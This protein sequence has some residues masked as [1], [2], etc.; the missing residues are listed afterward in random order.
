MVVKNRSRR[1]DWY[2]RNLYRFYFM[3]G[4][5]HVLISLLV[6][7]DHMGLMIL[8]YTT[9][10]EMTVL[11]FVYSL[12]YLSI[13]V[14]IFFSF[15]LKL[16]RYTRKNFWLVLPLGVWILQFLLLYLS[17]TSK[18]VGISAFLSFF[19]YGCVGF[20][21]GVK[22]INQIRKHENLELNRD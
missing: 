7:L 18:L 1:E 13:P 10:Y 19:L 16:L 12:F 5:L 4:L 11:S 15:I 21:V 9:L 8:D 3:T 17:T 20:G 6:F 22:G 2:I 14:L